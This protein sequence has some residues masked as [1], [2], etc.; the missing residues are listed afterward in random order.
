MVITSTNDSDDA[1]NEPKNTAVKNSKNHMFVW[2]N[3]L[4]FS[5][6]IFGL[7][8]DSYFYSSLSFI[9]ILCIL[10]LI[11]INLFVTTW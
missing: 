5:M 3:S 1:T 4:L 8:L 9:L 7:S 2:G 10:L 6:F 11:V